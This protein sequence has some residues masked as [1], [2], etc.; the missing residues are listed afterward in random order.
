MAPTP[1][2]EWPVVTIDDAAKDLMVKWSFVAT[3]RASRLG[4]DLRK[5]GLFETTIAT[6]LD[7]FAIAVGPLFEAKGE[8]VPSGEQWAERIGL[9]AD[10]D[11]L[12]VLVAKA[13]QTAIRLSRPAKTKP[14]ELTPN[15]QTTAQQG[16]Q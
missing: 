9:S 6:H 11:A 10:P 8:A 2:I 7:L 14:A 3:Y 1:P 13:V 5:M 4:I 15:P 12:S 16:I